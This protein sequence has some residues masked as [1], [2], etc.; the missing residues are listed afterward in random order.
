[1]IGEGTN[2]MCAGHHDYMYL[3]TQECFELESTIN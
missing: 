3:R 1:M 2:G